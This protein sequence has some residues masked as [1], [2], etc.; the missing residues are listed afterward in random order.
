MERA[1]ALKMIQRNLPT[2]KSTPADR[3]G[4]NTILMRTVDAL[5]KS[6]P[7]FDRAAFLRD[8]SKDP[9][10][11]TPSKRPCNCFASTNI[12]DEINYGTGDLDFNGFWQF[13][14]THP[15]SL[16]WDRAHERELTG[17]SSAP[18]PSKKSPG[19]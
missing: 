1:E 15:E 13:P 6:T 9:H 16:A 19:E 10:D 3:V 4:F 11:G 5:E 17:I 2:I 14:C 18:Q 8:V 12:A 7:N